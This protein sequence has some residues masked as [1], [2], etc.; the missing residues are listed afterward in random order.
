[1]PK[2]PLRER[3]LGLLVILSLGLI[4]YPLIFSS[5]SEFRVSR[6]TQIPQRPS[7]P[8]RPDLQSP[9][10]PFVA[11]SLD[12]DT[13]F[14]PT[15]FAQGELPAQAVL[16]DQGLP[17]AWLVQAGSFASLDNATALTQQLLDKG[18]RAYQRFSAS[19]DDRPDLYKV[20]VGPM[21]NLEQAQLVREQLSGILQ[22]EPI[23]LKFE[24]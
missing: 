24:P 6:E 14:E 19:G 2:P 20:Y 4:F 1:M 16:N 3:L 18:F 11:E 5:E 8:S 9:A 22:A 7:I 13:L 10:P 12:S 17:N 23:L 15:E 21:T